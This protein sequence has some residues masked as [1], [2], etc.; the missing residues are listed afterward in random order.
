MR[1]IVPGLE[2]NSADTRTLNANVSTAM[3]CYLR[4]YFPH[5]MPQCCAQK[6]QEVDI[7]VLHYFYMCVLLL[8]LLLLL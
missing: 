3:R 6:R 5:A 7:E 1:N 8:L 4:T 2:V